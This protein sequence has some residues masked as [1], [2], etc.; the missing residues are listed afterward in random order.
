MKDSV[1]SDIFRLLKVFIF[2][3]NPSDLDTVCAWS[4][5][6]T[7]MYSQGIFSLPNDVFDSL[8]IDSK[9]SE[10]W[11]RA[12][13]NSYFHYQRLLNL[14]QEVTE[15]LNQNGIMWAVLKGF[16]AAIYYPNPI[17]RSIGDIDILVT[18]DQFDKALDILLNHGF[19][20]V[21]SEKDND[22]SRHYHLAKNGL[23]LEL[24]RYYTLNL[25]REE[26]IELNNIISRGLSHT[27][28]HSIDCVSFN[29]LPAFEN[30]LVI[31]EHIAHHIESG[32]GLRH[33]LDFLVYAETQFA[34]PDLKD[35]FVTFLESSELRI[36][37]YTILS[38]GEKYLGIKNSPDI[39]PDIHDSLCEAFLESIF[40]QG[41]LGRKAGSHE[42]F[43]TVKVL[44]RSRGG[45]AGWWHYLKISGEYN[46]VSLKKH[47]WLKP[48]AR[49]YQIGRYIRQGLKRENAIQAFFYNYKISK[50]QKKLLNALGLSDHKC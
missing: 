37:A 12:I 25:S 47:P 3:C 15:C 31:L 48:F 34:D 20:H 46:W 1:Y 2:S 16:S 33:I 32:V 14:Q 18:K 7:E 26:N 19:S 30:G 29:T 4:D 21:H 49:F 22:K 36:L 38:I 45:I 10:K 41:D 17:L 44:N 9:L 40:S 23:T 5:I 35:R 39:P 43:N 11:S 6:F 28:Q 13:I 24:H 8:P 50:K 27:E 42:D